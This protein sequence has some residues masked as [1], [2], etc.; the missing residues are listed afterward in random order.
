MKL[1]HVL[2]SLIIALFLTSNVSAFGIKSLTGGGKSD[3]VDIN[4]L[5]D[6]QAALLKQVSAALLSL[7]KS[8][9]LMSEAL[10]LKD[11][12]AIAAQNAA[13]LEAGE[14]T[15]KDDMK[16]QV[17]S[18]QEVSKAIQTK[19]KESETLS[20]ENKKIFS[21]S[22]PHYGIGAMG[23]VKSSKTAIE[24]AKSISGSKDFTV[25]NK[26]GPLLGYAKKSPK[27]IESFTS[28]TSCIVKFSKANGIDT[29][30][31]EKETDSWG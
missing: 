27:L 1:S 13:S 8:Q 30:D 21:K 22:L 28:C 18:S 15:G 14:L 12:A 25:L 10:G 20:A 29:S 17:T 9:V 7:A 2:L 19:L 4:A 5:M 6:D 3:S 24:Q 23:V 26:L 16:K 11:Q 31:L